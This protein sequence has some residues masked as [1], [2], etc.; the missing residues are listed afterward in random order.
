MSYMAKV[1]I[2]SMARMSSSKDTGWLLEPCRYL[3]V[4][5]RLLGC[6][7]D[8]HDQ[9][10]PVFGHDEARKYNTASPR[11]GAVKCC[12]LPPS[13]VPPGRVMPF[14]G[15]NHSTATG[16]D[17]AERSTVTVRLNMF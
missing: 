7:E 9:N 15:S 13:L 5:L 12:G 2:S 4:T 1:S 16:R 8:V 3:L 6:D 14:T 11:K 10:R 17:T